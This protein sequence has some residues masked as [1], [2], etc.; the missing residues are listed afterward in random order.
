MTHKLLILAGDGIGPEIMTATESIIAAL[1]ER[2][3]LAMEIEHALMGGAA[4][5]DCGVPLPDST[6]SMAQAADAVLLGAVGGPKWEKIER[7][8]RPERGLLALRSKLDLF[9]AQRSWSWL[10]FNLFTTK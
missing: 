3:G 4:I 1:S 8:H 5:D 6:L 9:L 2:Y 10:I 7:Q